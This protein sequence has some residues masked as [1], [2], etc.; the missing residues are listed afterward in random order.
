MYHAVLSK[1]KEALRFMRAL[2]ANKAWALNEK[3]VAKREKIQIYMLSPR[4]IIIN[5]NN[6]YMTKEIEKKS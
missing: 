4:L 2:S 1:A 6:K 3:K 5:M